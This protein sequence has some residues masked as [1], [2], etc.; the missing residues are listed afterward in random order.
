MANS[1]INTTSFPTT[2][3]PVAQG[4]TGQATASAAFNALAVGWD[5]WIDDSSHSWVYASATS[6][7]I[8]GIDLTAQFSKGTRIKLTQSAAIAYFV[9]TSSSFSTNTTVNITAGTSYTFANSAVSANFYSYMANPQGYPGSF[10]Y[11]VTWTG[12]S[13]DP[14]TTAGFSVVG[15]L[16]HYYVSG[17]AGTSNS[18]AFTLSIPIS[19]TTNNGIF[20]ARVRNNS[21]D[22]LQMCTVSS[23]I[24]LYVSVVSG[25][26]TWTASGGKGTQFD[27]TYEF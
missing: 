8:S 26:T 12:F 27:V 14:S 5:G 4:G 22:S 20:A 3:L 10:T 23:L 25:S 2:P 1:A 7:T 6:F 17:L 11:T 24:T 13:A 15:N 16:C 18:T 19:T 21:A 9:V